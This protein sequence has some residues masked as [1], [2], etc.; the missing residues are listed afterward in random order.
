MT[1]RVTK[2]I[3]DKLMIKL[4][5]IQAKKIKESHKLGSYSKMLNGLVERLEKINKF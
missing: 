5:N 2:V 3:N 4:R 1:Q